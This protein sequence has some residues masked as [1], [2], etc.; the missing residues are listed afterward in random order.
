MAHEST[1]RPELLMTG[2]YQPWDDAWLSAGYDVHRLWEAADRAAFLAEHGAGVRAIATRGDL[3][4]NAELIAALPKLE[5]IACYGVGTDAIDLAAARARGIRVTNTP[6]VLTGDVADLGVGLALAMMRRIG[7][8][9]AYVRSGAWR[10]GDM[11]LVTRLYGK[12]VGVV[13]FGRIGS[14]LARRLSGFDVELGYFDVAPREDS[15][16]RFFGDLAALAS[17]CDL[18]IVTL[19][20]GPTTRHLVDAAV[21]DALGPQGY[22]VNVSRGTTVDEPA[23]LDAL[24][25]GAIAGAALDVFWNEPNID[26]RFLALPNVL[27]QPHHAS[28]TI[29]TRQ[30]M[31][32]LVRDNLAAHFAGAPLVT[33]VA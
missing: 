18:L 20:G 7:A 21:L 11:P 5:I 8:G 2:P 1:Q 28:G 19:A 14:T 32:W 13:G 9:D 15:P 17:W 4:A 25:R 30:A 10:D 22:L 3:G 6:D 24:E 12:R 26:P 33:P 23:L 31:G 16:H 29:E 27:L